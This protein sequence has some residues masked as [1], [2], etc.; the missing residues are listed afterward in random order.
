VALDRVDHRRRSGHLF[1]SDSFLSFC[2]N[3]NQ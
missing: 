1:Q 2:S 3:Q